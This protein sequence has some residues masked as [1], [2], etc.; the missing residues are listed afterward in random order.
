MVSLHYNP[1]VHQPKSNFIFI[2]RLYTSL[3]IYERFG[4]NAK[5]GLILGIILPRRGRANI[6][7]T[8]FTD[9]LF[10]ESKVENGCKH[11]KL[12]RQKFQ[13]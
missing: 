4:E 3:I 5:K 11:F 2:F 1:D 13:N 12:K 6:W 7:M 9:W 10:I 8:L